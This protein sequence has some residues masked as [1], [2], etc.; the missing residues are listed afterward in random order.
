MITQK[1]REALLENY[2]SMTESRF[3]TWIEAQTNAQELLAELLTL[4]APP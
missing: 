3:M 2:W 1:Q 4:I